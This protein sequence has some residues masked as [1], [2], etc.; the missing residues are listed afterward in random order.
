MPEFMEL[1]VE[2]RVANGVGWLDHNVLGW[3]DRVIVEEFNISS[4]CNCILGQVFGGNGFGYAMETELLTQDEAIKYGFD[5]DYV[6]PDRGTRNSEW[7]AL[8]A[9]WLKVLGEDNA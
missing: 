2:D 1:S 8:Q 3:R 4:E 5:A 9:E 7:D 6:I